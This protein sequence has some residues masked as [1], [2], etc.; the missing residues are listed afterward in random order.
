[1]DDD[2]W[3]RAG[4]PPVRRIAGHEWEVWIKRHRVTGLC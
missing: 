2:P 3:Q 4:P 1:L